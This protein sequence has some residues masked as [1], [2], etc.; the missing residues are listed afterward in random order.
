MNRL[1]EI[2]FA[3]NLT[4][5]A[6]AERAEVSEQMISLLENGYQPVY[7][8]EAAAQIA[9]ALGVQVADILPAVPA[10]QDRRVPAVV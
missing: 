5:V 1:R 10:H 2:R 3:S 9:D 7:A 8:S 6:L 4:Q